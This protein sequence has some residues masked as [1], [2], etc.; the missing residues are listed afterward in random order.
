LP[1]KWKVY[2]KFAKKEK[3]IVSFSYFKYLIHTDMIW[4]EMSYCKNEKRR[5]LNARQRNSAHA[6]LSW[7]F[8]NIH[9]RFLYRYSQNYFRM[10]SL[11]VSFSCIVANEVCCSKN[12]NLDPCLSSSKRRFLTQKFFFARNLE[13][14]SDFRS[15][16]I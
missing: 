16:E 15:T 5:K 10:N 8:C 7:F 4:V 2:Q 9:L 1:L 6:Q 11:W 14:F 3:N 12:C 13:N